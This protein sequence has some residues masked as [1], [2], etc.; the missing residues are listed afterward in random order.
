MKIKKNISYFNA[1]GNDI[2][3]RYCYKNITFR[4]QR[5]RSE[6]YVKTQDGNKQ[7]YTPQSGTAK[8]DSGYIDDLIGNILSI[9]ERTSNC[10]IGGTDSLNRVFSYD[11]LYRLL[12][13]NG[14]ENNPIVSPIW[15]D[16]YRSTD[17][18][19]TTAYT[20][21]HEYDRVGNIQKLQHIGNNNFTRNF[22]YSNANNKLNSIDIGMTNYAFSYDACGN[23]TQETISRFFEWD[24]G[25]NMR[26][27]YNQVST[28]EPT[29]YAQYLYDS[30]GN[31]VK[32]IVRTQG[33]SYESV[34]YINGVFEY[35]T[36]GTDE[37]NTLHVLDDQSRI[38]VIRLGDDFGDSTPA[39]KYNLEDHLGS[40]S[41]LL[42]TNG[43]LI[44]KEE[45]YPF[46]E[47][48]FGSYVK[49][50]YRYSGKEKDQ[51]SGLYY[52]G[53]RYYLPM[54]CRFVSVDPL[55]NEV[56]WQSSYTGFDNDPINKIDPDGR[57]SMGN[58][59]TGDNDINN[60]GGQEE[61]P[62]PKQPKRIVSKNFGLFTLTFRRGR[63]ARNVT[64]IPQKG[65]TF[66]WNFTWHREN[67]SPKVSWKTQKFTLNYI[68]HAALQTTPNLRDY[69]EEKVGNATNTG[70][71]SFEQVLSDLKKGEFAV[72]SVMLKTKKNDNGGDS[73]YKFNIGEKIFHHQNN[74]RVTIIEPP[75]T[76]TPNTKIK[77]ELY[78][79]TPGG[80]NLYD[81]CDGYK[82]VIR[83][84]YKT[85]KE[86]TRLTLVKRSPNK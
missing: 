27:F 14:R 1:Y 68:D 77:G 67:R 32:K 48:S 72:L 64:G 70:G 11:P 37:Q 26:C 58:Q 46:G 73:Y 9:N 25:N 23:Q 6:K 35:K 76:I 75:K 45:Y 3:T 24:F 44:N 7:I 55:A 8:Q 42:E 28:A 21:N 53:A 33:G 15:D 79:Q 74:H 39:I 40:S 80:D 17:N 41:I 12:S 51:E 36:D 82:L 57:I 81:S 84:Q 5:I 20:Q 4:L 62:K 30:S 2:M 29:V 34:S 78:K 63:Y 52:Y 60:A 54:S 65:V 86:R 61:I 31:R 47:T 13:A 49:K 18:S 85:I 50:R 16:S 22:N 43:T 69:P 10:G 38:A 83:V 19:T 59:V 66:N 56:L 71:K